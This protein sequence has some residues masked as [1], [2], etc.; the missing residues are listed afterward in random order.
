M[1]LSWKYIP[2]VQSIL[3]TLRVWQLKFCILMSFVK[4]PFF[5]GISLIWEL[6]MT[7]PGNNQ[8]KNVA[9]WQQQQKKSL[10]EKITFA[11]FITLFPNTFLTVIIA[12]LKISKN[13][14]LDKVDMNAKWKRGFV[15]EVRAYSLK[16]NSKITTTAMLLLCC[17]KH[18]LKQMALVKISGT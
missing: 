8:M 9:Q 17:C 15:T 6:W 12:R 5:P 13:N 1:F 4:G 11:I 18:L 2:E 16:T 10:P 7:F 3:K 14:L